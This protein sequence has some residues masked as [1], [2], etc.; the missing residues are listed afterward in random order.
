MP[1]K[2]LTSNQRR[3]KTMQ[4][5]PNK[6][7]SGTS[8]GTQFDRWLKNHGFDI[9]KPSLPK[10]S[11]WLDQLKANIEYVNRRK[12]Y[13]EGMVE[14]YKS[15]N[16]R[17]DSVWDMIM[18]AESDLMEMRK[19]LE[20]DGINPMEDKEFQNALKLKFEMIKFLERIKFDKAKAATEL[21][22]RKE[23][24]NEEDGDM[25]TVDKSV[26]EDYNEKDKN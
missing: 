8:E 6:L 3:S 20:N 23:K 5:K 22:M 21:Q 13:L 12:K 4:G 18:S 19:K 2:K 25:F 10:D 24:D 16:A 17:G 1:K 7:K 11:D 26:Y 9:P 14:F 15:I